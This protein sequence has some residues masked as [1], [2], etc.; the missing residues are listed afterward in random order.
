MYA[1]HLRLIGKHFLLVIIELFLLSVA[2]TSEN[3][4]LKRGV[5]GQFEPK[6]KVEGVISHQPFCMVR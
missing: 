2:A 6:F 5:V 4:F 3:H 1:V